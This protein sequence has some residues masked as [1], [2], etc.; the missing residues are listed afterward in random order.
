MNRA[1]NAIAIG[2]AAFLL[3]AG[4]V[5]AFLVV[6]PSASHPLET[7]PTD[8]TTD[9]TTTSTSPTTT[10]KPTPT[11]T[12]TEPTKPPNPTTTSPSNWTAAAGEFSLQANSTN[13]VASPF[14]PK[15]VG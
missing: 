15:R 7:T 6:P 4:L 10:P 14:S 5:W 2:I 9:S 3:L 12:T 13:E 11:T 1:V 8:T